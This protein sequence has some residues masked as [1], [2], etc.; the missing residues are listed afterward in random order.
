MPSKFRL[1]KVFAP[2]VK[3]I[4]QFFVKINITP[5]QATLIMLL[6]AITSVVFLIFVENLFWFGIFIFLTGIMDGVDGAIARLSKQSSK[7]G[8]FFDSTMDRISEV[9]IY[10][11]LLWTHLLYFTFAP[12]LSLIIIWISMVSS[13]LISYSRARIELVGFQENRKFDTNI[14]LLARSERLFFIFITSILGYLISVSVFS[15]G[16]L[17]YATLCLGTFIYRFLKY[18]VFLTEM[19]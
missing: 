2:I 8:G 7:F 18:K 6:C 17:I 10:L 4:G 3:K 14:G 19:E 16:M 15:W 12:Y 9:I 11:G 13:N 5:N 1:R